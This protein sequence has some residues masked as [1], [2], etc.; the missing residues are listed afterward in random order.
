M[1]LESI[2]TIDSSLERLTGQR[3][4]RSSAELPYS[5]ASAPTAAIN[6]G[7]QDNFSSIESTAN[8]R[9]STEP[10]RNLF[11]GLTKVR[12]P[13]GEAGYKHRRHKGSE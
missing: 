13:M 3:T 12:T 9:G 7:S 8:S 10:D 5:S 2:D 1:S 11:A 4:D 6:E